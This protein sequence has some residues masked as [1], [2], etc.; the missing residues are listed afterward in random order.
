MNFPAVAVSILHLFKESVEYKMLSFLPQLDI[1]N[2]SG[3]AF[4]KARYKIKLDF[5]LELNAKFYHFYKTLPPKIWNGY[6]L[7]AGDG[8]TVG[9]PP[10]PKIKAHFGIYDSMATGSSVT[11]LAQSFLFYYVLNNQKTKE[12]PLLLPL[13]IFCFSTFAFSISDCNSLAYC[14]SIKP[15]KM[16]MS[17]FFLVIFRASM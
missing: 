3:A 4:S 14:V 16:P 1:D 6:R 12:N 5:F 8:T 2:V 9:L 13:S 17:S 10:S 7:I 11:C 15:M